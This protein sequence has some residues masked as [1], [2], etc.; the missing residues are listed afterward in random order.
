MKNVIAADIVGIQ[1][2]SLAPE[3]LTKYQWV[4]AAIPGLQLIILILILLKKA[5][6]F[7]DKSKEYQAKLMICQIVYFFIKYIKTKEIDNERQI[8]TESH[9]TNAPPTAPP[10]TALNPQNPANLSFNKLKNAIN[11]LF[12][13][14][15]SGS[16][17]INDE[18]IRPFLLQSTEIKEY[19]LNRLTQDFLH[20]PARF[21][22][23]SPDQKI[24]KQISRK[25]GNLFAAANKYKN[26]LAELRQGKTRVKDSDLIAAIQ[27]YI[28]LTE[29]QELSA[30]SRIYDDGTPAELQDFICQRKWHTW[31]YPEPQK[32]QQS[33]F[34][35]GEEPENFK[36][37]NK[38]AAR[39]KGGNDG[40][41]T[42]AQ[43]CLFSGGAI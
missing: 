28:E 4:G 18:P 16:I 43:L 37:K 6:E 27:A 35:D 19:I 40:G 33:L 13:D 8:A 14:P 38:Y 29:Y 2:T 21:S 32:Q 11:D 34:A 9:E 41:G 26:R 7:I 23:F 17:I 22:L 30:N 10:E 12:Y 42:P 25:F 31:T 36:L 5:D 39:R 15:L 1:R 24:K 3:K 20:N